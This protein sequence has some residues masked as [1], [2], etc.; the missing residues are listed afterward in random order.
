MVFNKIEQFGFGFQ[1]KVISSLLTNKNTLVNLRDI[2]DAELF[3]NDAL[4]WIVNFILKYF[5]KYNTHPTL[6]IL[7][8]EVRKLS[9]EILKISITEQLREAYK[10]S[11][12][13]LR[14]IEEEFLNFC[15]NQQLKKALSQ[16]IDLLKEGQYDDIRN[17]MNNALKA[18]ENKNNGHA[19]E[20]DVESRYRIDSRSPI[21]FP[22]KAFNDI[23]QGGYGKGELILLFGSPKGGKSWVVISMA[24]H[25]VSLGYNIV[26]YTFELS[27]EYV[28]QR[29]D[30]VLT[31]IAMDKL[32]DNRGDI[33]KMV[34][35]L[36]GKLRIQEFAAGRASLDNV[37]SNLSSLEQQEGF[38]PDAIFIDYL[39]LVKNRNSR[40]TERKED[41]DDVYTDARGMA[42]EKK[43]PVISPS[44][45]NRAGANDDVIQSDKMAGSYMK[46]A[47]CDLAI[48]LSRKPKDKMEGTGR[49]HIMANRMGP[50]GITFFSKIDTTKGCIEINE[51]Q[52]GETELNELEVKR[53]ALISEDQRKYLKNKFEN[54]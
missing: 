25:A 40:R 21:P 43:I 12:E 47:I 53:N 46:A 5:D 17:L 27:K 33:E 9:N 23:T 51:K 7:S 2:I 44:Q 39:D 8:I 50:D 1:I 4:K 26:F 18:G 15:K 35:E 41:L 11:E 32:K 20:K 30:A 16:S 14:Y 6:E 22:W 36:K 28:G 37:E 10:A 48:S 38:K 34:S 24:A 19:Y 29:F 49:F 13:D 52:M 3:G 31:Q 54:S 42:R 45:I